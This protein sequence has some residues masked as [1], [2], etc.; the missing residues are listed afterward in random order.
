MFL[1]LTLFASLVFTSVSLDDTVPYV[2]HKHLVDGIFP[3]NSTLSSASSELTDE[4]TVPVPFVNIRPEDDSGAYHV[5]NETTDR[6]HIQDDPAAPIISSCN[7]FIDALSD[8]AAEYT[9]CAI[10]Y[11]RP[12]KYCEKCVKQYAKAKHLYDII[13]TVSRTCSYSMHI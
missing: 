1:I 11:A 12:L 4:G 7:A 6:Q 9:R 8:A 2:G 5:M 3:P 10:F 13:M